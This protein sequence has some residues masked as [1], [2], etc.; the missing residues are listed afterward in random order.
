MKTT[1]GSSLPFVAEIELLSPSAQ[2]FIYARDGE[3]QRLKA[4]PALHTQTMRQVKIDTAQAKD[5]ALR[6]AIRMVL[7]L[8]R[9]TI[10]Q[11]GWKDRASFIKGQLASSP[12]GYGLPANYAD[13]AREKDIRLI[14]EVL[15][16]WEEINGLSYK[17]RLPD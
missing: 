3:L 7:E 1:I 11:K 4:Q 15:H 16:E 17:S 5:A 6:T 13:I 2:A 8:K 9:K 14:R 10:T 12:V